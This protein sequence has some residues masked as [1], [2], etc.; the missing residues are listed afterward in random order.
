MFS[1]PNVTDTSAITYGRQLRLHIIPVIGD[2]F[3]EDITPTNVQAIFNRMV[4]RARTTKHKVKIVLNMIFTQALEDDLIQKNPLNSKTIRIVG[5]DSEETPVY[6]VEQMQFLVNNIDKIKNPRDRAYLALQA[7]HPLRLEE[8]LGLKGTDVDENYIYVRQVVTHPDRNKPVIKEPKTK[9][10]KRRIDFV[11][12]M[13]RYI[14]ETNPDEFIIGGK[15]P[16]SYTR[17]RRMCERIQ[18]D[19]GFEEKITPIRFRTTVL[20]DLYDK[21]KDIK[22]VQ[23]AAGH[24]TAA[25][26]LKYYVKGRHQER[27]TAI[28]IATVYGLA[29]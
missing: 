9:A 11:S 23:D 21:T 12:E 18:R 29:N 28:P 15:T 26:P 5:N 14:P 17:V 25:M 20:T 3:I 22:Q 4:N 13:R 19:T 8:V 7:V 10:S 1:K 24:T 16:L 2:L 27:S 6:S